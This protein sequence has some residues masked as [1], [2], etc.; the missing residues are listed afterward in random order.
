MRTRA[1]EDDPDKSTVVT[2][3]SLLGF[4]YE[5]LGRLKEALELYSLVLEIEPNNDAI[6]VSRGIL[7]YGVS[8]QSIA[9]LE[10]AIKLASPLIWPYAFLAHNALRTQRYRGVYEI[11]RAGS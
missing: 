6:L 1:T 8:P 7:L 9:D 2:A 4:G 10:R 5:F 3:L 11:L